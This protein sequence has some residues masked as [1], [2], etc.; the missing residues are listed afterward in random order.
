MQAIEIEGVKYISVNLL[1]W[2]VG[3]GVV[4]LIVHSLD[5]F[6]E[7]RALR[8]EL[9]A[10]RDLA[11]RHAEA[12]VKILD[13]GAKAPAVEALDT[14]DAEE[15]EE[16]TR[17]ELL[18]LVTPRPATEYHEDEGPVLWWQRPVQEEPYVGGPLDDEWPFGDVE[19]KPSLFWTPL[20]LIA[21]EVM[22]SPE[23]LEPE[24]TPHAKRFPS[25][26]FSPRTEGWFF[27]RH[28]I[29]SWFRSRP[30]KIMS[31]GGILWVF[32]RTSE[33][34][35][36]EMGDLG[37]AA[38]SADQCVIHPG[39]I[40]R[41][42]TQEEADRIHDEI[43]EADE[44]LRAE[45]ENFNEEHAQRIVSA[46]AGVERMKNYLLEYSAREGLLKAAIEWAEKTNAGLDLSAGD[47]HNKN[48]KLS[49][50]VAAYLAV[51]S[52]EEVWPTVVLAPAEGQ[53][54]PAE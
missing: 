16:P 53:K 4:G 23:V 42:A 31:E 8:S 37:L 1:G 28:E 41:V 39:L 14:E 21:Q 45:V 35:E 12:L 19:E 25:V 38:L 29:P 15:V 44:K 2:I 32:D 10:Y 22:S 47:V 46:S 50:A 36:D 3:S 51:R 20:A 26:E 17:E 7:K 54:E 49:E 34:L 5:V 11:L 6:L 43:E 48:T 27:R 13:S 33:D 9:A 30:S 40:Y 52:P 24:V 18:D